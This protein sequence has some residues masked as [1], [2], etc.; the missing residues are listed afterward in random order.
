MRSAPTGWL[1]PVYLCLCIL[2][3]GAS[4]WGAGAVANALLQLMAVFLILLALWKRPRSTYPVG[5]KS[6]AAIV[7]V[8]LAALGLSLLPLPYGIWSQLPGREAVV[9]GLSLLGIG[10]E[11]LPL[12]LAP[13]ETISSA[14]WLLPPVAMFFLV[15]QTPARGRQRLAWAMLIMAFLSVVLGAAQLLSGPESPLRPYKVT[16][17]TLPVGFFANANHLATLLL[18]TL[19]FSGYFAARAVQGAS[20]A[21]RRSGVAIAAATAAFLAL[22]IALIGSLAGYGLLIVAAVASFLI[23]RRAVAGKLTTQAVLTASAFFV[24]FLGLALAGPLQEQALSEKLGDQPSSRK[25]IASNTLPAIKD[26][27]PVGS[28][29]GTFPEI[30]RTYDDPERISSAYV[31]HAHNDYLE[32]ALELGIT[33]ILLILA[34]M[35]WW[36]RRSV[37]AWTADME[38]ANLARAGSIVIAVVL[39]HSLVDY[40][41]RTSA[42]AAVFAMACALLVQPMQSAPQAPRKQ[43]SGGETLRHLEA[44]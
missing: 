26:F 17:P 16:N 29:L 22:G 43:R 8:Y 37:R 11:S 39:M 7:G 1:A 36:G 5:V 15:L 32:V 19:P 41:I 9:Q 3:G 12:S 2:L 21:K 40:P 31:N 13:L 14:L 28:G 20:G 44:T 34:F 33:G 10:A 23:F 35:L 4:G 30:Y 24:V 25:V 42:I 27:F 18:C 6:L 38:G